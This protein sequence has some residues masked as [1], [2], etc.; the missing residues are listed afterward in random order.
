M[1]ATIPQILWGV[2]FEN[3]LQFGYPLDNVVTGRRP[4]PGTEHVRSP[5]G[6]EDAWATGFDYELSADFRWIPDVTTSN[7]SA[8]AWG[9]STGVQAFL[10]WARQANTFRFVPDSTV[11]AFY[12]DGCYLGD[13]QEEPGTLELDGTR[14][15][16]MTLRNPTMSFALALRGLMFEYTPGADISSLGLNFTYSRASSAYFLGSNGLWQSAASGALRDR[17]YPVYPTLTRCTLLEQ[18]ATN[19]VLWCRDQTNAA[20]VMTTMT[21]ALDQVGIDGVANSASSL[22]ATAA[23]ATSLQAITL[24]SSARMQSAFVKRLVGSGTVQMTTDGGTT[25]MTVAVTNAWTRVTIPVQTVTNPSVGFRLVTGG[26]KIAVDFVQNEA[27][28]PLGIPTSPMLTTT[29]SFTRAAETDTSSVI[30]WTPQAQ[31]VYLKIV[32]TQTDNF[33][34]GR[35][36]WAL[37]GNNADERLIFDRISTNTYRLVHGGAA[38]AVSST[39]AVT[40]A[41]GDTFELLGLVFADG[42]VQLLI[43]R[44]GGTDS[45]GTRS[46]ALAFGAAWNSSSMALAGFSGGLV[47]SLNNLA[48]IKGG[49]GT[50]TNSNALARAA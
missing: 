25:W 49:Y 33:A 34:N 46:A 2:N 5:G 16:H 20:W 17:H 36:I 37:P 48:Q 32:E 50:A 41:A 22:L 39:V 8:T 23:N 45:V 43:S 6:V 9:G 15:L 26:D 28:T 11:P 27:G 12:V 10:D 21:P 13:P 42:S 19:I 3:V 38:S 29:A 35:A 30:I 7:P 40:V 24:S 14:N 44:N 47:D 31:F 4:R 18:A 1:A